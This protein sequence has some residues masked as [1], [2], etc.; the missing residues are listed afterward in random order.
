MNEIWKEIYSHVNYEV[1]TYGNIKN[2]ITNKQLKPNKNI[3]GYLSVS[4]S[5][6]NK[7]TK[8][9]VHR[10]VAQTFLPNYYNKPTVNHKNK[11]RSDNHIFNLEWATI[12]E[13]NIHKNKNKFETNTF[14]ICTMKS[15]WRIDLKTNKKLEKYNNLTEA[16][17]WCLKNNLSKSKYVKNG[18]SLAA[19]GKRNQ[20][21][22]YK[23]EYEI[24]DN[25]FLENEIWKELPSN[26]VNGYENIY[27][28][29][30]GKIKYTNG[31]ISN[32][33][34]FRNYLGVSIGGKNYMLHRL[35]C[36][37]FLNNLEN[38]PI[39][40]HKDG[41]KLN[42]I[43]NNLEWV[44][45]KE[46]SIHSYETGLNKNIKPVIQ[47]DIKMNKLNEF[48]S[49][50][51]ASRILNIKASSIG[52]NCNG[53][54]KTTAGFRFIFKEDYNIKTD[55]TSNF[56]K[57]INNK[58]II[59]FDLSFN[60][61]RE[62]NSVAE[63]SKILNIKRAGIDDCCNKKQKMTNGFIFML[64]K[65]YNCKKIYTIIKKTKSI[66]IV[67]F[68]IKMNKIEEFNSI[69]E[70]SKILKLNDSNIS[71]CCKGK[72]ETTGNFK[73]MYSNDYIKKCI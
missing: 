11:I 45:Y 53:R 58:E 59:Q 48:K 50:N 31:S 32:G 66:K 33:Y 10:L 63:A 49:I 67:Q 70:A 23:W 36:Q 62:F 73:F 3:Q 68:D 60:K 41:N 44:S 52:S 21:L 25:L 1:S 55:Y 19:L 65:N 5:K 24:L 28:S 54:I 27:I 20:A 46:N 39:V 61:L 37:V 42:A 56:K 71:S 12:I 17:D 7:P 72:R 38:K 14:N 8:F 51:E 26:L 34:K 57:H 69:T 2:K 35:V 6:N 13:Q 40:N 30:F 43:L 64:K 16:Q 22:G 9:L 15:I 4:L 47:F 18:I 29:S